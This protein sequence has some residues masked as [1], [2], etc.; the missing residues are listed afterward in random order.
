M[1]RTAPLDPFL[2]LF[3]LACW[4]VLVCVFVFVLVLG[5]V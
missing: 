4:C 5:L 1:E 2:R 3:A